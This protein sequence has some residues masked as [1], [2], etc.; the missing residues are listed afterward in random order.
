MEIIRSVKRD[1]LACIMCT[2]GLK[3]LAQCA[4]AKGK[5]KHM[6]MLQI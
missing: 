3:W 6:G 4:I 1:Y 2:M 5:M